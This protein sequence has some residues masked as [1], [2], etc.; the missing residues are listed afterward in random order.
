MIKSLKHEDKNRYPFLKKDV[1]FY[2]YCFLQPRPFGDRVAAFNWSSPPPEGSRLQA[3][4]SYWEVVQES[5]DVFMVSW[6][7][8]KKEEDDVYVK[9]CWFFHG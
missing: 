5:A 4:S 1:P 8:K 2:F 9:I 3:D 7:A 6:G